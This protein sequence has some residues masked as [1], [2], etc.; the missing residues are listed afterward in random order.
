MYVEINLLG[1]TALFLVFMTL[2]VASHSNR[3]PVRYRRKVVIRE[4]R[5]AHTRYRT[6]LR[7][8][9][10]APANEGTTWIKD[11]S[12]GGARLFLNRTLRDMHVGTP[13]ELEINLPY[14]TDPV[15]V[16]GNIVWSRESDA[17]F[18]F[19]GVAQG[20]LDK[21]LHYVTGAYGEQAP[22]RAINA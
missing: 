13:L 5:R 7:I 6:S 3:T 10:R 22:G 2:V 17:G 16:R 12:A 11:I 1:T 8:R 19:G 20:D 15:F 14:D 4:E 21:V 9:Y 18:R